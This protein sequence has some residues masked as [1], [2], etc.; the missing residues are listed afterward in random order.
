M[1][2]N[3]ECMKK[4]VFLLYF[5]VSG[6]KHKQVELSRLSRS[7]SPPWGTRPSWKSSTSL[8]LFLLLTLFLCLLAPL[9]PEREIQKMDQELEN[10]PDCHLV[11]CCCPSP[12]CPFIFP[13]QRLVFPV[14]R[15]S[16]LFSPSRVIR[17]CVEIRKRRSNNPV[18]C[19]ET[20]EQP[21][22]IKRLDAFFCRCRLFTAATSREE[23]EQEE[24]VLSSLGLYS[25]TKLTAQRQSRFKAGAAS[26]LSDIIVSACLWWHRPCFSF[27][28]QNK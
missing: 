28:G 16:A 9:W 2:T 21:R 24:E 3:A 14:G 26:C 25:I 19:A 20:T 22:R 12:L 18:S 27:R 4:N 7:A 8:D 1:T 10:P 13:V 11:S 15:R 6:T 23:E 17:R 5:Y